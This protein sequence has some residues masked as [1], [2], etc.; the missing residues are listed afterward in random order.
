MDN[1]DED[2]EDN[3]I[4]MNLDDEWKKKKGRFYKPQF[5]ISTEKH[6]HDVLGNQDL[7]VSHCRAIKNVIYRILVGMGTRSF[8][9]YVIFSL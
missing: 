3:I 8:M 4:G 9:A 5:N 7:K 1:L 2:E 6:V